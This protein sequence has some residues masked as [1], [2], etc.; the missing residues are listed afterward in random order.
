MQYPEQLDPHGILRGR[1]AH[2]D[3]RVELRLA[4]E[5]DLSG[6]DEL[7][8]RVLELARLADGDVV[9]DLGEMEFIGSSG[10]RALLQVHAALEADERRL[11]LRN[12]RSLVARV[13]EVSEADAMLNIEERVPTRHGLAVRAPRSAPWTRG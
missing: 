6:A 10:L 11:V 8:G 1:V 3:G 12:V 2:L 5:L 7:R 4:G 13:I 9:L